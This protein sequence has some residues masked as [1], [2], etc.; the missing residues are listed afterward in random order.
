[1]SRVGS[2]DTKP[3]LIIRMLLHRAGYRFKI[4]DKTLPGKPDIVL[5][6]HKTVIFIHGCFW[7]RHK[8]CKL[9]STPKNNWAFWQQKFANNQRKD[10]RARR[11]LNALGWRVITAWE[12]RIMKDPQAVINRIIRRIEQTTKYP[13]SYQQERRDILRAAEKK[14]R[15]LKD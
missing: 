10:A 12:C 5:P 14:W 9:A 3:E 4:N 2:R 13:R 7:H 6:K 11:R 1:M 8:N 15:Y